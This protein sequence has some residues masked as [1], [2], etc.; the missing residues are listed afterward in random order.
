[1]LPDSSPSVTLAG[2]AWLAGTAVQ[3]MQPVLWKAGTYQALLAVGV[4]VLVL[5]VGRK[6]CAPGWLYLALVATAMGSAGWRATHY[7]V[8]QLP[9]GLQ[10]Q[11]LELVGVVSGLPQWRADGARFVFEV[12]QASLRGQP[13]RVP[14]QLSLGWFAPRDMT[15]EPAPQADCQMCV[16]PGERWQFTVQLQ[17]PHGLRNPHGFDLE[18]WMWEQGLG[19]SGVVRAEP[20]PALLRPAAWRHAPVD[21]ARLQVRERL[22]AHLQARGGDDS[23]NDRDM[24]RSAGVLAALVMGDQSAIERDDWEIF[25]ITGVAHLMSISGLHVTMFSWLA[26][27]LVGWLWRRTARWGWPCCLWLPAPQAALWAGALLAWAYALFSGWGVPAQRTVCMLIVVAWLRHGGRQWPWHAVLAVAAWAVVV[28]DP[29]ALLQV[30]FWLSFAAVGILFLSGERAQEVAPEAGWIQRMQAAVL[31][32]AWQQWVVLLALTP[33]AMLMFAQFSVVGIFAN[34]VAVPLVTVVVTPLA[35]LGVF[36][37][38]LWTGAAAAVHA[39]I[40]GLEW[41]AALHWAS[42]GAALAPLWVGVAGLSGGVLLAL[43]LPLVWRLHGLVLLLPVL[44]WQAPR[45]PPGE[46]EVIMADIGQGG[47]VLVRTASHSLMY[48]AGPAWSQGNDAGQR[49]LLP[50]LRALDEQP[51]MLLLSHTDSDH[52]GGIGALRAAYPQA[53][54]LGAAL[55]DEALR[56]QGMQACMVGQKWRW[57]NVDFEIL[58]PQAQDYTPDASSNGLSCVL[59]I[60]NA[61]RTALLVGDVE[62]EQERAMVARVPAQRLRADLLL[63]AHHGSKTSTGDAWLQAVQ[64]Q[65]TLIQHGYRNRYRHPHDQVLQRLL[66]HATQ[67]V[68]TDQCGAARWQ[69]VDNQLQCEREK[70]RRY[71]QHLIPLP[72]VRRQAEAGRES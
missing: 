18:L 13:V 4:A 6:L 55:P 51:D 21:M 37:P 56:Q 29:W 49:V 2:L 15:T 28:L 35:M 64:P 11:A 36:W 12:E 22:L 58:N 32:F 1:M 43:R 31:A 44:S 34:A 63:A 8:Q 45:P 30:G 52:A 59:R 65:W 66:R 10:G 23:G 61:R 3:L 24:R 50:L 46:F 9:D 19:A 53:Q 5:Y 40:Q 48:D 33:L 39:M 7:Q 26:A 42:Y 27:G 16:Q 71:W 68:Q 57:D 70:H 20:A 14:Q 60:G 62:L 67:I 17:Q 54:W 41:L 25:R 47:A 69:S 72:E 38:P